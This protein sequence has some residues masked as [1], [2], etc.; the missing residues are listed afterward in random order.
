[1]ELGDFVKVLAEAAPNAPELEKCGFS[2][3]QATDFIK[4]F[5]CVQRDRPLL[6]ESGSNQLLELVREWDLSK[7]EIGMIRFPEPPSERL[8]SICVGYV[9]VDPLVILADTDEIAVHE[10]GTKEHLLWVVAKCGSKLLDA[11]VIAARFL[12]RRAVGTI[13]FDDSK[14]ARSISIECATAAGGDKY[15][16]FYKMLLGAE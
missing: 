14:L 7:V 5:L 1:M 8:G 3:E 4:S 6:L 13:D 15:L 16:D 9:E 2:N 11:L 10:L 12:A